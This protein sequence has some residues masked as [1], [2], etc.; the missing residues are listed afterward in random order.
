M[1]AGILVCCQHCCQQR[2]HPVQDV[3]RLPREEVQPGAVWRE[4][5]AGAAGPGGRLSHPLTPGRARLRSGPGA[6][7]GAGRS[8][9]PWSLVW[10]QP[11]GLLGPPQG[12][13]DLVRGGCCPGFH[14]KTSTSPCG[15]GHPPHGDALQGRGATPRLYMPPVLLSVLFGSAG[16]SILTARWGATRRAQLSA[17]GPGKAIATEGARDRLSRSMFC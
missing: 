12:P 7:R 5:C 17:P 8:L 11:E 2:L 3:G 15:K 1:A 9:L 10:P 13:A 16:H 14:S 4:T 6:G